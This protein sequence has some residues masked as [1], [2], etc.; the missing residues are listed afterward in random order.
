[1]KFPICSSKRGTCTIDKKD[2][3]ANNKGRL[4]K[5]LLMRPG[6]LQFNYLY[7]LSIF[8]VVM[9]DH[10]LFRGAPT[11]HVI[12][13]QPETIWHSWSIYARRRSF[14]TQLDR[15]HIHPHHLHTDHDCS[16]IPKYV[17]MDH[18]IPLSNMLSNV[19]K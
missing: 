8:F 9:M 15:P 2:S 6:I 19:T 5:A 10:T 11:V 17:I 12:A 18:S 7:A 16:L 4:E 13:C 1:M 3:T 14:T